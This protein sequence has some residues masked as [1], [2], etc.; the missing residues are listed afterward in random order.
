MPTFSYSVVQYV[1]DPVRDERVNVGVLV[2]GEDERF[3]SARLLTKREWGRLRRFGYDRDF[4]FLDEFQRQLAAEAVDAGQLPGGAAAGWDL[5]RLRQISSEWGGTLQVT[6][7]RPVLHDRATTL[8]MDLYGRFVADPS[9]RRQRARDRNWINRRIRVGLRTSIHAR[10]PTLDIGRHLTSRP[11]VR[12]DLEQ[13]RF[14][15]LLQ[16][17]RPLELMR[18]LS[19]EAA[20]DKARTEIDAIAW[21]IADLNRAHN[22]IPVTVVSIGDGRLLESAE[23]V[24]G[25]L[26]AAFVKEAEIDDW[27]AGSAEKLL[28]AVGAEAGA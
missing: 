1:P 15:F 10:Q 7:P 18:S 2:T 20:T 16:N 28:L 19:L 27:L 17:G 24:Y 11:Q 13:H 22:P 4:T 25:G 5:A 9:A 21:S 3:F 26:G 12:G 14:D 23:R 6:A 8:V